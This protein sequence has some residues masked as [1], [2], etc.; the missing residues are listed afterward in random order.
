MHKKL[1]FLFLDGVGYLEKDFNKHIF[2]YTLVNKL[3]QNNLDYISWGVDANLGVDG[4][5]Q[6]GTG[7]VS[8]LCGINAPAKIGKHFGPF[9]HPDNLDDIITKNIFAELKKNNILSYFVNAYPQKYFD[10]IQ[11]GKYQ[12]VFAKSYLLTYSHLNTYNELLNQKAL[13]GDITNKRWLNMGYNIATISPLQ[14]SKIMFD[15]LNDYDFIVYEYFFT[16]HIGHDRI[17]SLDKEELLS[18]LEDFIINLTKLVIDD[19]YNLLLCSDHGNIEDLSTKLHTNNPALYLAAGPQK[20]LFY[21]NIKDISQTKK[22]ILKYFG[23]KDV[24]S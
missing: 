20:H 4:L 22:A 23:V 15:L 5:P 12:G 1:I 14:A 3:N 8:I 11:N 10:T 9:A 2:P 24:E 6:S 13:S 7:Q 19:S 18:N 21:D 16:D 17:K